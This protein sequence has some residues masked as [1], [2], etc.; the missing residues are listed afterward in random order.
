MGAHSLVFEPKGSTGQ[1]M[2]DVVIPVCNDEAALTESIQRL[3]GYLAASLPLTWRITIAECGSVDATWSVACELAQSLPSVRAIHVGAAGRGR[4]LRLAW[5]SSDAAVVAYMDVGLSTGLDALLPLVAPLIS[6][7]SEIAIG[8]RWARTS[9]VGGWRRCGAAVW[10]HNL[11]CRVALHTGFSD[12]LYSFKAVRTE[13]A[14]LL[15]PMIQ[16][17]GEFFETEL[18]VLAEHNG[19]RI[20]E[21]SVDQV[22]DPD[23]RLVTGSTFRND[24]RGVWGLLRRVARGEGALA[25]APREPPRMRTVDTST[26]RLVPFVS[27]GVASTLLFATLFLLLCGVVGAA[28]GAVTAMVSCTA[29]N[30]AANRRFTFKVRGHARRFGHQ[31]R[32]LVTALLPLTLDLIVIA[33]AFAAGVT[34]AVALVWILTAVNAPTS[35]IKLTLL[36]HWVFIARA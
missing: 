21:I 1:P 33:V 30:T 32:G 3:H 36:R 28:A 9:Q 27:I 35:L 19:M 34:S 2:V 10:S 16:D 23:I 14:K 4:A 25:T 11:I 15:M 29:I 20:C 22:G 6:G 12:S 8:T 18:L 17:Q 5:A 24:V 13:V 7:H 26:V 31:L